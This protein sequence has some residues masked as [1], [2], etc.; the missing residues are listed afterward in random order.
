MNL[1]R[2][3]PLLS[4]TC[5]LV[6]CGDVETDSRSES[7]PESRPNLL[8]M[9]TDDQRY[10]TLSCTGN[11]V[12]STPNIDRLASEGVLFSRAYVTTSLCCPARA[13]LL[14]G[15]YAHRTGIRNNEDT[16]AFL[17]DAAGFPERL[18][19]AGYETAF[20]GKWHIPNPGAAPQP[21]F[22]H[23]V[24]F[25]GQGKYDRETYN[26]NGETRAIPGFST[27]VLTD[28]AREWIE[29]PRDGPFCLILSV[30]NLHGPYFP[31]KRH[32]RE[33]LDVEFSPPD[34]FDDPDQIVADTKRRNKVKK[35]ARRFAG[36][37]SHDDLERGYH[38]LVLSID[39]NLGRLYETLEST[40]VMDRT[41]IVFTSDG[42]FM[43]GEHGL[44]RK[45]T[46]Y[47][48]SIHVP[49]LMRL[50]GDVPAGRVIDGLVL[51][52]DLAP[53]LLDLAGAVIPAGVQGMSFVPL[54][55]SEGSPWRKDFL[56]IDG[57]GRFLPGPHEM[58]VIGSR[59]KY[60]RNRGSVIEETL[61]DLDSDPDERTDLASQPEHAE[62]LAGLRE[63]MGTLVSELEAP[64]DWME[65]FPDK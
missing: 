21:G 34:S 5:V 63:R 6:G 15:R 48:P 17:A 32:R 64:A 22:D 14:T 19:A 27:D 25:E 40:G 24:S 29:R 61:F 13:S 23:W 42:G 35:R 53:T 47:E 9:L 52:I 39:D 20:F 44:Y 4:L 59:Y 54:W 12:L 16:T 30:K 45:R 2:L 38:Q 49:L 57:W 60:V 18:Q 51:N 65:V 36:E 8:L 50:P 58:A 11:E 1:P 43:W 62:I 56:Y 10:D 37:D 31:P 33:F 46:A 55:R 26:I 7:R 41:A 28:L 3:A